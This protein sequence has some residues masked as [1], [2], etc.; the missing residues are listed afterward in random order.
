MKRLVV[1]MVLGA[2]EVLVPPA[3]GKVVL[4]QGLDVTRA[5]AFGSWTVW[6]RP[7][8]TTGLYQLVGRHGG[9]SF[10]LPVRGRTV[11]FDASI[12]P[13]AS[14]RPTLLYS[15]C[16]VEAEL[17]TTEVLWAAGRGCR[18]YRLSLPGGAEHR[19]DTHAPASASDYLPALWRNHLAFARFTRR[20]GHN[21]AEIRVIARPSGRTSMVAAGRNPTQATGVT[22]LAL[23]GR[24]VAF[25]WDN[26]SQRCS[27]ESDSVEIGENQIWTGRLGA[28]VHQTSRFCGDG[29]TDV[30]LGP[31]ALY[32]RHGGIIHVTGRGHRTT[33]AVANLTYTLAV[34]GERVVYAAL[35]NPSGPDY[36]LFQTTFTELSRS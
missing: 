14:G 7:S 9:K 23:R 29:A 15:R 16:R 36:W 13:D 32:Y 17:E 3:S 21:R 35:P 31:R 24:S 25:T 10:E 6:S 27:D 8:S 34:A 26:V 4:D 5:A 30:S 12:G 1:V 18:I 22:S 20:R 28:R 19:I 11:P 33:Y 2:L